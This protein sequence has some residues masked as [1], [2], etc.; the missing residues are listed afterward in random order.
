M[1]G[2]YKNPSQYGDNGMSESGGV[3]CADGTRKARPRLASE[4]RGHRIALP[5]DH[6]LLQLEAASPAHA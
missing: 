1:D 2:E 6:V 5:Y 4:P 3:L